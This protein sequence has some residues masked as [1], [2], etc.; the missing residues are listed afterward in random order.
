MDLQEVG[1]FG[2][3]SGGRAVTRLCQLDNRIIACSNQDGVA[4]MM[5]FYL[6]SNSLAMKQPFLFISK[7][8]E[9]IGLPPDAELQKMKLTKEQVLKIM[10]QL[11]AKRDSVLKATAESFRI[12][13]DY[14]KTSHESFSDLPL[15][16]A[17]DSA[18]AIEC[19]EILKVI[20]TYTREFFDKELKGT[21][22][23]I[24]N[25][26]TKLKY[27]ELVKKYSHSPN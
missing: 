27:V 10:Q 22:E 23:P 12:V 7:D 13:L 3:S 5:P 2:H 19:N 6:D 26:Q 14:D 11:I 20:E 18:K 17:Q 25:N 8:K 16:E 24:L 1:A 4:R 9:N 15:F 21:D